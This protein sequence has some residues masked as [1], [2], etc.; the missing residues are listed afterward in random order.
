MPNYGYVCEA[1]D[2]K[3]EKVLKIS[4]RDLPTKDKCPKCNKKKI[5]KKN[6]KKQPLIY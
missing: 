2:Y 5:N 4:E 3:F 6:E 1:C